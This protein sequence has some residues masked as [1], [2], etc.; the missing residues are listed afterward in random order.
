MGTHPKHEARD[1]RAEDC[2]EVHRAYA[3]PDICHPRNLCRTLLE[4]GSIFLPDSYMDTDGRGVLS[5]CKL[6]GKMAGILGDQQDQQRI[7]LFARVLV[8]LVVVGSWCTLPKR[9][10]KG[11]EA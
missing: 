3:G 1:P 2:K 6:L 7:S 11:A 5:V 9:W 10:R 8:Y 4:I